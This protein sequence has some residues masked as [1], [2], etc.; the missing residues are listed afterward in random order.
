VHASNHPAGWGVVILLV[1]RGET[2]SRA[3]KLVEL[4]GP[5]VLQKHQFGYLG[6]DVGTCI[7]IYA[8]IYQLY[9]VVARFLYIIIL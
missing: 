4:F 2:E 3:R 6:A 7:N 9:L 8:Y 1:P 5:V